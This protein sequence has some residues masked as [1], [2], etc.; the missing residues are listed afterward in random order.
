MPTLHRVPPSP[1]VLSMLYMEYLRRGRPEGLSF[2]QYLHA[3]GYADR[4][5]EQDGMDDNRTVRVEASGGIELLQI[6]RTPVTGSLQVIVLLIDFADRPG[7]LPKRRY[8][9]LLFSRSALPNGSMRDYFHEVSGGKVD[10]TGRVY[11]WLR[12][13]KPYAWY[14]NGE[15]GTNAMSYPRNAQR[16]AEDAVDVALA[17]EIPFP[18]EL[19]RLGQG[20]ATALFLIHAGRGAEVLPPQTRR[21]EI[22][23][24]KWVLRQPRELAPGLLAGSYLTVP[25]DC[26]VGVC[27]HELGHLAFQ[28]QDFYDPNYDRDGEHWDGA[29]RWDLMA[30]GANNGGGSRP[31]HPAGLHKLQH[32][33]VQVMSLER[34]TSGVVLPPVSQGV[35]ARVTSP[36]FE[37]HQFLLLENRRREGFDFHLPGEGLLA[38]RID[39]SGEMVAS[40]GAGMSLLEADG[41]HDLDSPSD[42]NEGDAGDPFPGSS[43]TAFLRDDGSLCTSFP[44]GHRSGISLEN[45]RIGEGGEILFDLDISHPRVRPKGPTPRKK[46]PPR[47]ATASRGGSR[48]RKA[49]GRT[50]ARSAH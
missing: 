25:E 37:R 7:R 12:L 26:K 38:W 40:R 43:H 2:R 6:P 47:R 5:S 1:E 15:S 44:G 17:E 9:D 20:E 50:S 48:R 24:H 39:L 27:A 29:G 45:I 21:E 23:S 19:D 3:I 14:S 36:V 32:G 46:A 8:E 10:V 18:L 41:R 13:P 16:M 42:W 34:S 33:W 4:A 35:V 28:W 31:A 11:G 30:G 49:G 22:W